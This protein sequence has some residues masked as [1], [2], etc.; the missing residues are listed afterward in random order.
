MT[1]IDTVP[2]TTKE[3]A[4][5][6]F[7]NLLKDDGM[8]DMVFR[9]YDNEQFTAKLEIVM[10]DSFQG[11]TWVL[12]SNGPSTIINAYTNQVIYYFNGIHVD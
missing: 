1:F 4:G 8:R 3:Q 7:Y 6:V 12:N 2:K 9:F 10:W 11:L 5:L